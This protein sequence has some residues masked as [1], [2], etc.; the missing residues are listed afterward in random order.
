MKR[1][2]IVAAIVLSCLALAVSRV[3]KA[4]SAPTA[5]ARNGKGPVVV[6][7]FTSEGC[8]S[9]P[10]ADALLRRLESNPSLN[11]AEIIVLGWHVDYWDHQGWRDRFSAKDFTERQQSYAGALGSDQ[12]YTPQ[13]VVDGRTE[14]VGS[15]E[16]KARSTIG[17]AAREVKAQVSLSSLASGPRDYSIA[18]EV[19]SLPPGVHSAYATLVIT[20]T[21]LTS[22][23]K[24][25]EN[26]GRTLQHAAVVRR[27]EAVGVVSAGTPFRTKVKLSADKTWRP[28]HLKAA[29]LLEDSDS[30]AIVGAASIPLR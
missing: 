19:T 4:A 18:I 25:G 27:R 3:Q 21:E 26:S 28:E 8:S 2:L 10:P 16:S 7:L 29:V 12:V 6:E 17:Q 11:G 9:C 5:Q 30:L 13:M 22:D 1:V 14:F 24:A 20:E 15:D 23:V